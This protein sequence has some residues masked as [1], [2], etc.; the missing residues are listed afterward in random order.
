M[1][2]D[3]TQIYEQ[4]CNYARQTALSCFDRVDAGLGRACVSSSGS[5]GEYRAE[6]IYFCDRHGTSALGRQT[7]RRLAGRFGCQPIGCRSKR[8]DSA[9]VIRRLKRQRD[10]KVK[11]PQSLVEELTRTTVLGQLAWQEARKQ[12]DFPKFRPFLEK[13]IA[14]KNSRP[15][16]W[17]MR[18]ILTTRCLDEFE[19]DART[20]RCRPG[21]K[22]LARAVGA[23]GDFDSA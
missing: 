16:P 15:K 4:V 19:P 6:Q 18:I 22:R 3:A 10:K 13:M 23:H 7:I 2:N 8:S 1:A 14:L 5:A 9:V 11:L 12:N 20:S 21:V 17:V